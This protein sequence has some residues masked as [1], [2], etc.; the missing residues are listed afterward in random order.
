KLLI[1]E[2]VV[3][4][5]RNL[6]CHL[7]TVFACFLQILDVFFGQLHKVRANRF[8]SD[9]PFLEFFQG[10]KIVEQLS[11]IVDIGFDPVH[12]PPTFVSRCVILVFFDEVH[13]AEDD[14]Q[15]G[16]E[17]MASQRY[18]TGFHLAELPFPGQG[19]A[20]IFPDLHLHG[21]ILGDLDE[22]CEVAFFI[23]RGRKDHI[24][25]PTVKRRAGSSTK[26]YDS[27]SPPRIPRRWLCSRNSASSWMPSPRCCCKRRWFSKRISMQYWARGKWQRP[28]PFP[29][30]KKGC[31]RRHHLYCI[32]RQLFQVFLHFPGD[33]FKVR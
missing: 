17:L 12:M 21:D 22:A 6:E 9:D 30:G 3:Y 32:K 33:T 24:G 28:F 1:Q 7:L 5:S 26:K 25:T 14:T 13:R 31:N 27:S 20:Q 18:E 2:N 10:E 15:R 19:F 11:E 4:V 8:V 29:P 16:L 23:P